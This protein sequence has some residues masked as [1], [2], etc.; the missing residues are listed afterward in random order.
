MRGLKLL[1]SCL[2]NHRELQDV[3]GRVSD[4]AWVPTTRMYQ[5]LNSQVGGRFASPVV[6][7]R[8]GIAQVRAA[9]CRDVYRHVP[10]HLHLDM[11]IYICVL[12]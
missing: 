10:G 12:C 6:A 11:D 2:S 7:L 5:L 8:L 9:V 4:E 3:L 1:A